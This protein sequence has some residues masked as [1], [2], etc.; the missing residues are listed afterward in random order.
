MDMRT[1]W[2]VARH[3]CLTL[4]WVLGATLFSGCL[5]EPK[6]EDRW[7]R[8]D[9]MSMNVTP[10]QTVAPGATLPI[11]LQARITYRK[12]VTGFVVADLRASTTVSP[13]N[14]EIHP[15]ASRLRMAQD[16]DSLLQNSVTMGRA[17]RAITGWDH[18]M[19]GVD[20]NFVG[21]VPTTLGSGAPGGLFLVCYLGSGVEVELANGTDT[22]IV[23]PFGSSA[24]ELL[25]IGMEFDVP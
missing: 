21:S 8:I 19:Q 15:D 4:L 6:L 24:Y 23:T 3:S 25:P 7:T 20:L 22:L 13:A 18:L 14:V 10:Y 17:T 9:V 16:I 1:R 2:K 12:I 11:S 5:G